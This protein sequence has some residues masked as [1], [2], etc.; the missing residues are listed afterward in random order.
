MA[1][2]LYVS[3]SGAVRD[4]PAGGYSLNQATTVS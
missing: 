3:R 1:G 4:T 2:G